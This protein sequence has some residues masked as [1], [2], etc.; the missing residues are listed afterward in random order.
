M[1]GSSGGFMRK[2]WFWRCSCGSVVRAILQFD[3]EDPTVTEPACPTCTKEQ[4]VE[5]NALELLVVYHQ[6]QP[7][8]VS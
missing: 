4:P 8:P 7:D 6:A 2:M 3:P 1:P 5:G